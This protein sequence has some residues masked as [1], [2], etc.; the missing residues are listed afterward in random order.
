[1]TR[2][3]LDIPVKLSKTNKPINNYELESL[4]SKLR[5]FFA[6]PEKETFAWASDPYYPGRLEVFAALSSMLKEFQ[7]V[8]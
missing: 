1:M 6:L 8:R 4:F 2:L 5:A 3:N 7:E